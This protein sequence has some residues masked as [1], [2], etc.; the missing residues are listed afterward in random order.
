MC[1]SLGGFCIN[2]N[3]I[4]FGRRVEGGYEST[5]SP[6]LETVGIFCTVVIWP[7]RATGCQPESRLGTA[8]FCLVLIC[9][10]LSTCI[11]HFNEYYCQSTKLP[12]RCTFLSTCILHFV[13]ID[14]NPESCVADAHFCWVP[15]F[16]WPHSWF[17]C[18]LEVIIL[19]LLKGGDEICRR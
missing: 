4:I 15:W 2:P 13:H 18:L 19:I 1:G 11:L 14:A 7:P 10:F 9:A 5:L 6:N 12:R 8:H 16:F 17:E 3:S